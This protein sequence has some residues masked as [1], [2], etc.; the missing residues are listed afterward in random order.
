M[1]SS[2]P[3]GALPAVNLVARRERNRRAQLRYVARHFGDHPRLARVRADFQIEV[4]E[5][6]E[7]LAVYLETSMTGVLEDLVNKADRRVTRQL[8]GQAL[9]RYCAAEPVE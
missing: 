3:I 9:E 6:L 1:Y 7:R 2:R 8:S 4:R 5:K